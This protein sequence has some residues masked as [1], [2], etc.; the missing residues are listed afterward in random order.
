MSRTAATL[1]VAVVR[2]STWEDFVDYTNDDGT[3]IDLT[4][5]SARLQV[6]DVDDAYTLGIAPILEC[7]STGVEP[8]LSIVIPPGGTV[9]SR[10]KVTVKDLARVRLL[11]PDNERKVRRAWGIELFKPAGVDPE[12]VVPFVQGKIPVYGELVRDD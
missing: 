7:L 2:G 10:L 3:P 1:S 9:P 8:E 11:N 12:Y 4:G 5:Y 6:R